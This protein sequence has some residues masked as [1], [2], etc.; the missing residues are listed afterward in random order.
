[1]SA[2]VELESEYKRKT[3]QSGHVFDSAASP[4]Y[5]DGGNPDEAGI[6]DHSADRA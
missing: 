3:H 6:I 1:M 4:L 5:L 2:N